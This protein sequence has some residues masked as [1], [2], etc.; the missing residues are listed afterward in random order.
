MGLIKEDIPRL[1][2]KEV[3]YSDENQE[4]IFDEILFESF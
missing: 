1:Y 2:S 3:E 4:I